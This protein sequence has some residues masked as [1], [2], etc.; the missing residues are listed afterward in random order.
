MTEES[1]FGIWQGLGIFHYLNPYI[2][3]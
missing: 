1:W 3:A 2:L